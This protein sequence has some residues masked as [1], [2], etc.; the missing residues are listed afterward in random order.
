MRESTGFDE[1]ILKKLGS[2]PA[3]EPFRYRDLQM[4]LKVSQIRTYDPGELIFKEGAYD[5]WI[6]FI[7]SGHASIQKDQQ[8]LIALRRTGDVFGEM[9]AIENTIRAASVFAE[10]E[11]V[12]LATDVSQI[13]KL[14][15][16]NRFIFRYM[17]FRAFSEILAN[18][19][20]I[21]TE[22]LQEAEKEL[23]RLKKTQN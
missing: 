4:L 1:E 8:E 11:T 3:F 12:C 20:R 16:E 17:I 14:P 23:A 6:Y 7:I 22:K 18:R 13:E 2:M 15:D 10:K 9:G 5:G 21:T 19:L